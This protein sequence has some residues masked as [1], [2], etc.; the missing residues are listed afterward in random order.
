MTEA[1]GKASD[2]LAEYRAKRDFG[3]TPEPGPERKADSG[4][5]YVIQKHAAT[6]THFDFRLEHD[7]VLKSWAVT[8]G[9]STDPSQKRLAVRTEDHPLAYGGFEGVI[10]KGE[11][12]GGPVMLWDRGSWEPI[13]D[14]D[15]GLKKGHLDFVLHG[16]RLKGEWHLVRMKPDKRGQKRENWLLIKGSDDAAET[17]GEPTERFDTSVA[18][19]RTMDEIKNGESAVW[20]SDPSK[21]PG[22]TKNSGGKSGA[23][24]GG[25]KAPSQRASAPDFVEPQLAT[26]VDKVPPGKGWIHEVKFDGYRIEARKDGDRVTLYSRSG[27]DWTARFPAIAKA[28]SKL[29]CKSALIDGEAAFV[30]PS[31]LTSFK[32]LQ[33]HID[34]DNPAIRY[35]AFDLL[36]LDGKDLRNEPLSKRKAALKQLF[37][38]KLPERLVY[39][40]DIEGEGDVFF[41]KA[42]AVGLEGIMCKRASAP[43]RSGRSKSWLKVKCSH[44]EEFVIGGYAKSSA[45]GRPFASLLLGT[46]DGDRLIFAGKVGTGFDTKTL[47]ALAAKFKPLERK[48]APFEE[49]PTADRRD[50]VWLSPK[51]VGAVRFTEWTPE[52]RLR[53]PSFQGLREDKPAKEV[54]RDMAA[55]ASEESGKMAKDPRFDGIELSSPD[56][57]LYPEIGL[58]KLGLAEYYDKVRDAMLPYLVDRPISLVRCPE[59]HTEECFFQRHAMKG[60]SAAIKQIAIPGGETKEKY[61]YIENAEGLFALVQIGVLEI[62]DWGVSTKALDKPDRLVF[63]LDPDEGLSLETLKAATIE[64]RDFLADLGLKS[65]LKSTGGKGFHVVAP[66]TPKAGWDEVKA[67]CKAVAD[68]LVTARG[69]RYTATLSKSAREGKIFVD[70]LRNQRGSSAIVNFSTRA[71]AGAPVAT[72][73]RWD[74]LSGLSQAAAYT[75][76]TLPRRLASLKSDPWEGFF[77]TRQSI[78]KKARS[79][80]GLE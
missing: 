42:C 63:D 80:L 57:V 75:V 10:P 36:A 62:H 23:K 2:L 46:Y 21:T 47:K 7:G 26:L 13:G 25:E 48:T 34:T 68:A 60:M 74:E 79:T 76:S 28:F 4:N 56:R 49:V 8:R 33:E 50:A 20:S 39:S 44:E 55:K 51:L 66:L 35:Y 59:G 64:V 40:D 1:S 45:R 5:S 12:G 72:P 43:Y 70:Y 32:A 53:H 38:K 9:P 61:L 71:R 17:G 3:K 15:K 65:F 37:A 14:V 19:G 67:F 24:N 54:F 69:D 73:L 58:T 16:K 52:G 41:A 27:L 77:Q 22:K 29:S 78:S 30:L 6:R 18:S 31:G 11:Y